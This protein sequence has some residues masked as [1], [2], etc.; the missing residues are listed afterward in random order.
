MEREGEIYLTCVHMVTSSY[1]QHVTIKRG[2][3]L[4][5]FN[6]RHAN[7]RRRKFH[8]RSSP[9]L[10]HKL[11]RLWCFLEGMPRRRCIEGSGQKPGMIGREVSELSI[12]VIVITVTVTG[13]LIFV[14]SSK[15]ELIGRR[16]IPR[17]TCAASM[18]A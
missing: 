11:C 4:C 3:F 6:I 7:A 10:H 17:R 12:T 1:E 18:N 8:G 5:W 16:I 15:D 2:I 13:T 9:F 14:F